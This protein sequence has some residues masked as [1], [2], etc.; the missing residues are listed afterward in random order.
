MSTR[1]TSAYEHKLSEAKRLID[2]HNY[3]RKPCPGDTRIVYEDF[4]AHLVGMG[5]TCDE[6]LYEVTAQDLQEVCGLPVLMAR[7][8]EEIF[9]AED[10]KEA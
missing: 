2:T 10:R 4:V 6:M 8:L 9:H 7:R 5:G 3:L 1:T